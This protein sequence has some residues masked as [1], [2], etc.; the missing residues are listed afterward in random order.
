[1]KVTTTQQILTQ[2]FKTRVN[3]SERQLRGNIHYRMVVYATV[4]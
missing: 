4:V 1:M 2:D 3:D